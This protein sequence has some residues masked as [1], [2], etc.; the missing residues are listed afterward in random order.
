MSSSDTN[1]TKLKDW[2][3]QGIG[4][5]LKYFNEVYE[6]FTKQLLKHIYGEQY[7]TKVRQILEKQDINNLDTQNLLHLLT[8]LVGRQFF[9]QSEAF[10][11]Y[12]F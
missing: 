8:R 2:I 7:A 6:P 10:Y 5:A 12:L 4:K 11:C 1:A 3:Y 9:F